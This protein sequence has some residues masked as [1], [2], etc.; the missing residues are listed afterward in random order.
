[1]SIAGQ[2]SKLRCECEWG[3]AELNESR[4]QALADEVFHMH[5]QS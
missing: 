5:R 1:M 4:F 2:F 3:G